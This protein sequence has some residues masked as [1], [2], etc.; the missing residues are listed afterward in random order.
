MSTPRELHKQA[1]KL[2][3]EAG[4]LDAEAIRLKER[5][6]IIKLLEPL[7]FHTAEKLAISVKEEYG[8]DYKYSD[9][10]IT[11]LIELIKGETNA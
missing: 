7:N 2:R 5:E 9:L 1:M 4:K 8:I 3:I 11:P 6:R 10:A